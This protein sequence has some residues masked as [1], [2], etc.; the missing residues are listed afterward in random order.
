MICFEIRERDLN[1]LTRTEV[2]NLPGTLFAGN[3]PLLRPFLKKLEAILPDEIRGRGDSYVLSSL[4]NHIEYV[5][6]EEGLI[7]VRSKET[8]VVIRRDELGELISE[9]YPTTSHQLLNL[10]GLLFLQS[11]P[12]LQTAS[13]LILRR[14][15]R[16]N[17]PDGRRTL[18][19]IFHMAVTAID[20][21][22]EKIVVFF[23]FEKLPRRDDGTSVLLDNIDSST[24]P[25]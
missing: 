2:K 20:A 18:R 17:I 5:H 12:A 13:A 23:D 22:R 6:A 21:D 8:E 11:G 16:L 25:P 19:Y 1:E 24:T 4:R 15:H 7:A 14:Q 10:P 3:S 9:K